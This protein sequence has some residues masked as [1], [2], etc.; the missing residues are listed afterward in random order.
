LED[1]VSKVSVEKSHD[2]GFGMTGLPRQDMDKFEDLLNGG[3][4]GDE[5]LLQ[6]GLQKKRVYLGSDRLVVRLL[7]AREWDVQDSGTPAA[8]MLL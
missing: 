6:D 1:C 3:D 5:A 8:V 4:S 2:D 7:L